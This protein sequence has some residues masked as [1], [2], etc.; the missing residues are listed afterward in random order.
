[1]ERREFTGTLAESRGAGGRWIEVPFDAKAAFGQARA[2]VKGTLNGTPFR[3]RLAVYGGR[4]Y[5]GL[6]A[7]IRRAAGIEVGDS[8]DV[9]L[10][11]DEQPREVE[12][13][14]ALASAL[15]GD[16]DASAA[17]DA[18]SFTHKREYAQWIASAKRAETRERRVADALA[19]LRGGVKHP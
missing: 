13:P 6:R 15:V 17:Y 7:E 11:L 19:M 2:P 8:V 5:L 14:D 3:G 4:T 9:V 10:E 16:R 1:M 18:L 12:L